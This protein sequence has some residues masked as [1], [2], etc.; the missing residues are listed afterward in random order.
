MREDDAVPAVLPQ[1]DSQEILDTLILP[2]SAKGAVRQD[3]PV[4]MIVGG[5]PGAGKTEIADLTGR[6]GP[7]R[8]RGAGLPRPLQGRAPALHRGA[9]RRRPYGGRSRPARY[10]PLAGC[11]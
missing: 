6:A 5:Q 7:P 1:E 3:R 11:C 9:G 10:E 8:Q 2:A 4:V